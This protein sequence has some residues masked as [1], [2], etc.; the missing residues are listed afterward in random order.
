MQISL[1]N[2]IFTDNLCTGYHKAKNKLPCVA[3]FFKSLV[4][5][6]SNFTNNPQTPHHAVTLCGSLLQVT[7]II[8]LRSC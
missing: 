8:G 1:T 3:R 2:L 4:S 6:V 7:G 5:P